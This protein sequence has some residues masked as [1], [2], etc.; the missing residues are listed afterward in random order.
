MSTRA[1][2]NTEL[3]ACFVRMLCMRATRAPRAC[4]DAPIHCHI[5]PR[6]LLLLP[7]CSDESTIRACSLASSGGAAEQFIHTI[8]ELPPSSVISSFLTAQRVPELTRYLH[9]LHHNIAGSNAST[10]AVAAPEHTT[11]LLHCLCKL[12]QIDKV[13]EFVRWASANSKSP[14]VHAA[15]AISVLRSSRLPELAVELAEA[16]G[17][18]QLLLTLL[19]EETGAYDRALATIQAQPLDAA[20]KSLLS[21]ARV[22]LSH[23][24]AQTAALLAEL[25]TDLPRASATA[26]AL[27]AAAAAAASSSSHAHVSAAGELAAVDQQADA[28]S[29]DAF[30]PLFSVHQASLLTFLAILVE[31]PD[32]PAVVADTL[33]ALYLAPDPPRDQPPAGKPKD[34]YEGETAEDIVAILDGHKPDDAEEVAVAADAA[35]AAAREASSASDASMTSEAR[36]VR[37]LALLRRSGVRLSLDRAMLLCLQY[38]WDDGLVLIYEKLGWHDEL[39]QHFIASGDTEA[40]VRTCRRYSETD[41]QMW[42]QALRHLVN[43]APPSLTAVARTESAPS[44]QLPAAPAWSSFE[45]SQ[46][47]AGERQWRAHIGEA[48]AAVEADELVAPVEL[49]ERLCEGGHVPIGV[50]SEVLERHL[51]ATEAAVEQQLREAARSAEDNA[52]MAA[53]IEEID[54]GTR[55]F[56]LSKCSACHNALE[57]PSV[58]FLCMHSYHQACLGDRDHEC[59]VCDQQRRRVAEHQVQQRALARGHAAF[60]SELDNSADGFGT[61]AEYIGRGML[62]SV[63]APP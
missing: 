42:L 31:R 40:V 54:H 44:F 16:C 22:L 23:R 61:I 52:K 38:G 59:L 11:L 17:E 24:P 12:E 58:H 48:I 47:A 43:A 35:A 27:S 56:Q 25:C 49:V 50:G 6:S 19:L 20:R 55:V 26:P 10:T 8:G 32:Q 4:D 21:T 5:L 39:L 18:T 45:G 7:A 13:G 51:R 53:E 14:A 30:I 41:P 62:C 15:A 1:R 46:Q 3:F 63:D 34:P 29:L 9:A 2:S 36:R 57:V 60:Y 28:S 33:L 37:A